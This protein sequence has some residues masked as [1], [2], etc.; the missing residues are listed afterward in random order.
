LGISFI[1]IEELINGAGEN[2]LR[3]IIEG[4]LTVSSARGEDQIVL[5]NLCKQTLM[6]IVTFINPEKIYPLLD[7]FVKAIEAY[8]EVQYDNPTKLRIIFHVAC[9]LERMLLNNGLVYDSSESE[10]NPKYVQ[11]LREANLIFKE[12]LSISLTDDEIY[13]IVDAIN[14]C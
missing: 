3:N 5:K 12:A 2:V 1:S 13:Y 11:A 9:A 8:L 7:R 14:V 6:E 10:L 4:K